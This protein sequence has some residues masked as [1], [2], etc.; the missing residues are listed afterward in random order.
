VYKKISLCCDHQPQLEGPFGEPWSQ[1]CENRTERQQRWCAVHDLGDPLPSLD[2]CD[3]DDI[4]TVGTFGFCSYVEYE[5]D[6]HTYPDNGRTCWGAYTPDYPSC[7][8]YTENG[9]TCVGDYCAIMNPTSGTPSSC[10]QKYPPGF[11][12]DKKLGRCVDPHCAGQM[13]P[14]SFTNGESG[15]MELLSG[16]RYNTTGPGGLCVM[17]CVYDS[18]CFG[19]GARCIAMDFGAS[20]CLFNNT[21]GKGI[22]DPTTPSA[23]FEYQMDTQIDR[24]TLAENALQPVSFLPTEATTSSGS[25]MFDPKDQTCW[26]KNGAGISPQD[27]DS[28][29]TGNLTL[30]CLNNQSRFYAKLFCGL[31]DGSLVPPLNSSWSWMFFGDLGVSCSLQN[32]LPALPND[33]PYQNFCDHVCYEA[34]VPF[35]WV[36]ACKEENFDVSCLLYQMVVIDEL[37][38]NLCSV[39]SK[40]W[41]QSFITF[42]I[43]YIAKLFICARFGCEKETNTEDGK[44][45]ENQNEQTFARIDSAEHAQRGQCDIEMDHGMNYTPLAGAPK[46]G[47]TGGNGGNGGT[48]GTGGTGGNGGGGGGL[49]ARERRRALRRRYLQHTKPYRCCKSDPKVVK[50]LKK[51]AVVTVAVTIGALCI[52]FSFLF[53]ALPFSSQL[54]LFSFL[55]HNSKK[56]QRAT[57]Q[58]TRSCSWDLR[59]NILGK[60]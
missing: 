39:I 31:F 26:P 53:L 55:A 6:H 17:V 13:P 57:G 2:V 16:P 58:S 25:S 8:G 49:T 48:G 30:T 46:E 24:T 35:D 29:Y 36:S 12:V 51:K 42:T 18:D 41:L 60:V 33:F 7:S 20:I 11:V 3:V 5:S 23:H 59:C 4:R 40:G 45:L 32:G 10:A 47:D 43:L 34:P 9:Y 15:E 50:R 14:T 27:L 1:T 37:W 19:I 44:M 28:Y 22:I 54:T 38:L 56:S 52:S 21:N